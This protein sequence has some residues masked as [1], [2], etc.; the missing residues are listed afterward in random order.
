M[1]IRFQ[2][3]TEYNLGEYKKFVEFHVKKYHLKYHLYTLFIMVLLIFC[4]VV[5]FLHGGILL[6]LGFIFILLF[7]LCYRFFYPLYL[8][9]K[10][11]TSPKVKKKMKNTY[12]F[13]DDFVTI[14]ND[15]DFVKLK[16]SKFYKIHEQ[17][18]RFLF[19]FR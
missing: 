3:T 7:F 19:I 1:E 12:T 16:Y 10:E 11:A 2:N 18:D 15:T 9:K 13:Y 8:T 6:G 17:N 4:M 5:Q 14:K